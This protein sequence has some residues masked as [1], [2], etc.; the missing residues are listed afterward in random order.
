MRILILG[1]SGQLGYELA[2]QATELGKV[3]TA[4]RS[5][6]DMIMD[7]LDHTA[8][9][10]LFNEVKPDI[11]INAI[12]YTAVDKAES[13]IDTAFKLNTDLPAAL[14]D[15]CSKINISSTV[16]IKSSRFIEVI[17]MGIIMEHRNF[18]CF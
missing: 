17:I 10:A 11:V 7:P 16:N 3:I 2:R 12:A 15:E 18:T 4:G 9:T 1:P 8:L 13:E 6:A 5:A 14:A